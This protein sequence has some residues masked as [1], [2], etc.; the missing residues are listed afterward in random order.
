MSNPVKRIAAIHDLSGFGRSSLT[1]V[2]PIV[3]TMGI[4]VCPL[5]TA[6][7]STHTSEFKNYHMKDLTE[8]MV[9]IINHWQK[10]EIEFD[11]IYSGFL[12]S[13]GQIKVV[14]KFIKEF[15]TNSNFVVVDPVMGDDGSTYATIGNEMILGMRELIKSANIITPN[16][17]EAAFLLDEPQPEKMDTDKIKKWARRLSEEGPS[18]VIITSVPLPDENEMTS[19]I[20][21][22]R[23]TDR[24]W[25]VK[26]TYIPAYFP[27]TG[28]IFTSVITGCLLQGDSL[29]IAMD[30][31]VQFVSLAIHASYGHKFPLR[32]GVLLERVLGSL[33]NPVSM[34]TF[35]LF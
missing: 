15:K 32:E 28:D 10:L 33:R 16:L 17:T 3:S 2:I 13:P 24:F 20:A 4:Q 1:V 29:P 8:D 14:S 23:E 5:P 35:Q 11:A 19:V 31:A 9:G 27:G 26:C 30:R 18:I 22:D 34:S 25:Q 21:Y 12:G 6:L 7:L